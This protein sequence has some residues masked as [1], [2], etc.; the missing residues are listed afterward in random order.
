MQ[1]ALITLRWVARG[2]SGLILLFWGFFM[3]GHLLGDA[4]RA[5]HPLTANDRVQFAMMLVSLVGLVAAWRW[6]L[7][8]AALTLAALA[9]EAFI[10]PRALTGLGLLPPITAVLFVLCWWMGRSPRQRDYAV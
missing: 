9:V 4:G 1:K 8:G 6:E 10:N 5:S 2:L 7:V 3:A